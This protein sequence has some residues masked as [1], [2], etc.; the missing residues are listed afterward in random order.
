M[1]IVFVKDSSFL[2]SSVVS[3]TLGIILVVEYM[4]CCDWFIWPF[5]VASS[6]L[7]MYFLTPSYVKPGHACK[8]PLLTSC[9]KVV[10][11]CEKNVA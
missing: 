5:D 3:C 4:P 6:Y 2:A 9:M 7:E 1:C 11:Q 10:L 8:W